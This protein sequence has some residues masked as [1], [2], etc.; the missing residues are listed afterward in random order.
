MR[1][2]TGMPLKNVSAVLAA[3][4]LCWAVH[5]CQSKGS[6]IALASAAREMSLICQIPQILLFRVP[7]HAS[8]AAVQELASREQRT[9]RQK[10]AGSHHLAQQLQQVSDIQWMQ[11]LWECKWTCLV[12]PA[13]LRV[14]PQTAHLQETQVGP[15][16]VHQASTESS[17]SG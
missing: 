12:C 3:I 17:L 15:Q 16:V 2:N 4:S 8:H 6:S 11:T 7:V 1:V 5:F 14:A 10:V 13:Q 9:T